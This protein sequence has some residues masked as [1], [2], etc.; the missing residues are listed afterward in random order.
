MLSGRVSE[1]ITDIQNNQ[2][3]ALNN[4]T[5]PAIVPTVDPSKNNRDRHRLQY[6]TPPTAKDVIPHAEG[7]IPPYV[8][9]PGVTLNIQ[10]PEQ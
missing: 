1:L 2:H 5:V 4:S 9:C 3:I 7:H 10:C 8:P 6:I